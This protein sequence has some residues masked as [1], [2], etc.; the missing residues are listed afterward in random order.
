[1][2]PYKKAILSNCLIS[3]DSLDLLFGVDIVGSNAPLEAGTLNEA[4][5]E[6]GT[7]DNAA[8]GEA[9]KIGKALPEAGKLGTGDS[10]IANVEWNSVGALGKLAW[11]V[12]VN[13]LGSSSAGS[14]RRTGYCNLLTFP[15]IHDGGNAGN[16]WAQSL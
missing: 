12:K 9:V 6:A 3:C 8:A 7:F 11:P 13:L 1:M 14:E 16:S 4:P 15:L 2:F 10:G 5:P